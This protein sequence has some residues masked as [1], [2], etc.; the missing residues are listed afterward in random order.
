MT[1]FPS[2]SL[3]DELPRFPRK[4][5]NAFILVKLVHIVCYKKLLNWPH[6]ELHIVRFLTAALYFCVIRPVTYSVKLWKFG[7]WDY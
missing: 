3:D 2:Y 7:R 5:L 4:E 1:V 6:T